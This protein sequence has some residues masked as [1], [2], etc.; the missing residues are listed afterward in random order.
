[1]PESVTSFFTEPAEF[2]TALAKEGISNFVITGHGQ[3]RAR[4]TSIAL[5]S[6]RLLAGEESLSRIAF[7]TVPDDM[8]LVVLQPGTGRASAWGGIV[9]QSGDIVTLGAGSRAHVRMDDCRWAT[10]LV[11]ALDLAGF[12][13]VMT[14]DT[15]AVP[16]CMRRWQ[17]PRV[18]GALLRRL[19]AAA[20]H[21]VEAGH[22]ELIGREAAHGLDQQM[23]GALVECLSAGSIVAETPMQR[24]YQEIMVRFEMLLEKQYT[25]NVSVA[26]IG[27]ALGCSQRVLHRCCQ[28]HLGITSASYLDLRRMQRAR[29][30]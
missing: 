12:G 2:A 21:T 20:I 13:S 25:N 11:S 27:A 23:I 8:I 19:H 14:G 1:V 29:P 17:P 18:A 30:N 9:M 7:I 28:E 3:F 5:H 6:F 4:L 10:I 24:R 26:E 15:F 16:V 22:P